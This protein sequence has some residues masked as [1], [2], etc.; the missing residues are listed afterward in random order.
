MTDGLEKKNVDKILSSTLAV[1]VPGNN[2]EILNRTD[3]YF[4]RT[5]KIIEQ[6]GDTEV[7]YAVFLR[8]PVISA[9]RIALEWLEHIIAR[10]KI[11]ASYKLAF[12]E[13]E[14][15]GAGLPILYLK[16][17]F[18]QLVTLETILLQKLAPVVLPPAMRFR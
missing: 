10:E 5:Q 2:E 7:V 6:Y 3:M 4:V 14:W 13:G 1:T 12:P 16:G 9:P 17:S 18:K 8:R 11:N 15:V